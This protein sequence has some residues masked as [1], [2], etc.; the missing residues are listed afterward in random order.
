M[1]QPR[2]KNGHI[3]SG[4]RIPVERDA[5]LGSRAPRKDAQA[6]GGNHAG[7]RARV[8]ADYGRIDLAAIGPESQVAK[9]FLVTR[10]ILEGLAVECRVQGQI[11]D[12]P[13]A[14]AIERVHVAKAELQRAKDSFSAIEPRVCTRRGGMVGD[15]RSETG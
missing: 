15:Q 4:T 7:N 2:S 10:D 6:V 13:E 9:R 11:G 5:C 12:S 1:P 3:R 8:V 14:R